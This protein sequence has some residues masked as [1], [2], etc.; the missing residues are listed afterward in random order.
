MS[1]LLL[2]KRRKASGTQSLDPYLSNVILHLKG[3]GANNST[4]IIDS[5]PDPKTISRFGDTKISTTQSKYGGSSIL[6]DG[7]GDYLSFTRS[8][9]ILSGNFTIELWI[10]PTQYSGQFTCGFVSYG[11]NDELLFRTNTT[12][13]NKLNV[14]S[15]QGGVINLDATVTPTLNEWSHVALTRNG[16][17][18]L[19]FHNGTKYLDS[20]SYS[21]DFTSVSSVLVGKGTLGAN[22]EYYG[23]MDSVR[24]TEGVAR[25]IAN[26]NPETDTYLTY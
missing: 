24:I 6:F 11:G 14:Y 13:S 2:N 16:G 12:S 23:F 25:Y 17:N 10:Y 21:G 7:N 19:I 20:N 22:P 8:S 9:S 3:D 1:L 15:T 18:Y 26:F 5:S 4:D